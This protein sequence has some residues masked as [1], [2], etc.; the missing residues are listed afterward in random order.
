MRPIRSSM[1]MNALQREMAKEKLALRMMA[2]LLKIHNDFSKKVD[3][4]DEIIKKKVG[5]K[6][7]KSD[8]P[9]PPGEPGK[10]GEVTQEH[11]DHIVNI[12]KSRIKIPE[13]KPAKDGV[14][15]EEHVQK[16]VRIVTAQ[17][18][19]STSKQEVDPVDILNKILKLPKGK[20]LSMKHIDG[21]EQTLNAV[22]KQTEHGYLHGGG[23]PSLSA[24][25]GIQ[26]VN[27]SDGGFTIIS[28]GGIGT[29]YTET[30]GGLI[31]GTN[32]VYTTAHTIT[33][34]LSFSINGEFIHPSDYSFT[35]T[36]ITF[37]TALD[38]SLSG[39]PFTIIY[40]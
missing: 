15:T 17:I 32:K 21:L 11:I 7:D 38:S 31:N 28:T 36:T 3:Q 23:V 8:I 1:Q 27:K 37:V 20:G 40:V 9:G 22:K 25:S 6:G 16:V 30:P 39:K 13:P 10:D 5:P 19:L 35:G 34:I 26:L 29:I 2:D 24:G 33:T 14:F 18:K 4:L 12:V